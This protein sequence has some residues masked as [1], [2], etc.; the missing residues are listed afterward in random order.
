M[1]LKIDG[2][3]YWKNPGRL[4]KLRR[5]VNFAGA[6]VP[7]RYLDALAQ[8]NATHFVLGDADDE[9]APSAIVLSLPPYFALPY[10]AH[11]A[12]VFMVVIAGSL[13]VPG[14]VLTPGDA[15]MAKA[16]EFYGPE[17]AGPNGCTR[18]EFFSR[19]RG[20]THVEYRRPDGSVL[21]WDS[22]S[23]EPGPMRL[24]METVGAL[25]AEAKAYAAAQ[26]A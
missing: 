18:I 25:I 13:H 17:V 21:D 6:E 11:D 19:L 10:H 26:S 22:L 3:E 23:D 8:V 15:Q 16:H 14:H 24:G 12:D 7:Q 20:A 1:Y 2:D 4:E 9:E 5:P